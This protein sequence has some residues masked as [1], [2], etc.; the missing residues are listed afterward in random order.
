MLLE[1][2]FIP[3]TTPFHPDG[4]LHPAKLAANVLRYSKSP[5]AGLIA[6]APQAGEPTLLNDA[7]T[8]EALSTIA[9]AAAPE[10]V[11]LANISRDS[12]AG[13]LTL[14]KHAAS[15][16]YDAVLV[17][18]PRMLAAMHP[19]QT[20]TYFRSVADHSPIPIILSSAGKNGVLPSMS[21]A[22]LARQP[23]V[24]G[25]YAHQDVDDELDHAQRVDLKTLLEQTRSVQ[26]NVTVTP[27]F[28]AVT[29][30]ML[31][32]KTA[33]DQ[34]PQAPGLVSA[35]ALAR[36]PAAAA[37]A[38]APPAATVAA[39]TRT[40]TVGFQVLAA[41]PQHLLDALRSGA[42]AIAPAFA[43][44]APQACYEV[45]A[46]WKDNDQPLAEEKQHRIQSAAI[47]A[48]AH[49]PAALK[50][51]CDLN[52]YYGGPARPPWL[53]LCSNDRR[54]LQQGMHSLHT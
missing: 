52:G 26:H 13:T 30:R 49:G 50:F 22:E 31:R 20:M 24:L 27:V 54:E 8:A 4:R 5:A 16:G 1:G 23:N 10:K 48:E 36:N 6:L 29:N 43:A 12:V 32:S 3:L 35:T 44:C 15:L 33:A 25:L 38:V 34:S 21:I 53:P 28:A 9:E 42:S 17:G 45:Y 41:T 18:A 19:R 46:A 14:A 40:K 47:F 37:T 2:L 11:L 51:G 39:K 7:E